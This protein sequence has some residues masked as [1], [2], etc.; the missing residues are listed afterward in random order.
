VK[1]LKIIET[2]FDCKITL[3]RPEIC[4]IKGPSF[5]KPDQQHGV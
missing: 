3:Y 1:V 2:G 5:Y 4:D